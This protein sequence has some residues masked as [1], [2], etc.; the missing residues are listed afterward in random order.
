MVVCYQ[1]CDESFG[2]TWT[3]KSDRKRAGSL[4]RNGTAVFNFTRKKSF[5]AKDSSPNT[6]KPGAWKAGTKQAPS[7][8][9]QVEVREEQARRRQSRSTESRVLGEGPAPLPGESG[10]AVA[11]LGNSGKHPEHFKTSQ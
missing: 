6:S 9:S 4:V 8:G 3:R 2:D 10:S 1:L 11:C 7:W 5:T